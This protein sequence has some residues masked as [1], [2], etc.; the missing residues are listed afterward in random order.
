VN[1]ELFDAATGRQADSLL[2]GDI[3]A[4]RGASIV[5]RHRRRKTIAGNDIRDTITARF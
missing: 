4:E 3:R 1:A 2:C 5:R